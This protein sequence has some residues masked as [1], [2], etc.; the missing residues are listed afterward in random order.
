MRPGFASRGYAICDSHCPCST[1]LTSSYP[2][3]FQLTGDTPGFSLT[4]YS[5]VGDQMFLFDRFFY[6]G[7]A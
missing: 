2:L 7:I 1:L 4:S 5:Q 6:T 3:A